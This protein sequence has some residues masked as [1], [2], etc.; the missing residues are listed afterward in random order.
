MNFENKVLGLGGSINLNKWFKRNIYSILHS[1]TCPIV[2]QTIK[3]A[4]EWT[5]LSTRWA[6][7]QRINYNF[8]ITFKENGFH[9]W[10]AAMEAKSKAAL[11][12]GLSRGRCKNLFNDSFILGIQMMKLHMGLMEYGFFERGWLY[13]SKKKKK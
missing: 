13:W 10:F 9:P 12:V 6:S 11:S 3:W 5:I 8:G 7:Y 1:P 2:G 4:F